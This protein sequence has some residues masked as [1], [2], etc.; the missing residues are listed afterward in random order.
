[1][2]ID[3]SGAGEQ[4]SRL[5]ALIEEFKQARHRRLVKRGLAL[6]NSTTVEPSIPGIVELPSEKM[7]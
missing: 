2:A 7:N 4:Q 1:M 6:L 5:D 3:D